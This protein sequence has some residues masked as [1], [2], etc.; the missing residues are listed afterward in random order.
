MGQIQQ[1][2]CVCNKN[3][4]ENGA[5]PQI[6]SVQRE[7]KQKS[8]SARD[9]QAGIGWFISW[10]IRAIHGCSRGT[11][12][13]GNLHTSLA[14]KKYMYSTHPRLIHVAGLVEWCLIISENSAR[15]DKSLQW[16]LISL[17]YCNI[18]VKTPN[19]MFFLEIK[20]CSFM[21]CM[22]V[23]QVLTSGFRSNTQSWANLNLTS[24]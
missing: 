14:G 19:P 17:T 13:L 24:G 7:K 15:L 3:G 1:T 12:T 16:Q 10:K 4:S 18:L 11:P 20:V 2:I 21:F 9:A 8:R 5:H 22:K 23:W 6:T